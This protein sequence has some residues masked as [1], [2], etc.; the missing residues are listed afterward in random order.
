MLPGASNTSKLRGFVDGL[1]A[2]DG[3]DVVTMLSRPAARALR[4]WYAPV[5]R[6]S[7]V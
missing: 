6:M 5:Y 2:V 1:D 3:V 7:N 4:L